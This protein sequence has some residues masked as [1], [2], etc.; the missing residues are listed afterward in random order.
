MVRYNVDGLP[1]VRMASNTLYQQCMFINKMPAK[2]NSAL[3]RQI[4]CLNQIRDTKSVCMFIRVHA[5]V[6]H[7]LH[8]PPS[9]ELTPYE[10]IFCVLPS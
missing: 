6:C 1:Q 2:T 8:H 10:P 5:G 7:N 9:T 4:T 3:L